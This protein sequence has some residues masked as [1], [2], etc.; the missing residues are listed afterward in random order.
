MFHHE[1]TETRFRF[2]Q[3]YW[4]LQTYPKKLLE[5]IHKW[6]EKFSWTINV[7][8]IANNPVIFWR[9]DSKLF[10]KKF[11]SCFYHFLHR[12]F[13]TNDNNSLFRLLFLSSARHNSCKLTSLSVQILFWLT[14]QNIGNNFYC[15]FVY[16]ESIISMFRHTY[17]QWT[18][19]PIQNVAES[20][21]IT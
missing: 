7:T 19:S 10:F 1:P 12:N 5:I 14:K 20:S 15:C 6:K 9:N 4:A 11:F 13:I 16:E 17:F 8:T 18:L 2:N 21:L 3:Y